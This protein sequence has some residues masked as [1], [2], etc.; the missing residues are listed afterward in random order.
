MSLWQ[1]NPDLLQRL[2]AHEAGQNPAFWRRMVLVDVLA[3]R[4]FVPWDDLVAAVE[5]TCG[6]G[7]F[8]T[9]PQARVWSDIRSLR[10]AGV[11]IGYSRTTGTEGY[12]LRLEAL[13]ES[14][15]RV[16]RQVFRE[17]DFEHVQRMAR[18]DPARRVE[19]VFAMSAFARELSEAG[20]RDR[21]AG[22]QR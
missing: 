1:R 18:T 2:V 7:C 19:A 9:S 15:Q 12:Y 11:A 17:L 13:S 4:G 6:A 8:G 3:Q 21:E 10:E 5:T 16:I 20:R 22:A 14:V